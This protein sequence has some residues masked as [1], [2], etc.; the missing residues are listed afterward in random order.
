MTLPA[1]TD[2]EQHSDAVRV[3]QGAA[4]VGAAR[5]R[6]LPSRLDLAFPEV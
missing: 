6:R 3:G 1:G 4:Q 5:D 2:N